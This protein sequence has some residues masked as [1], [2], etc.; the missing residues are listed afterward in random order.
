MLKGTI[1]YCVSTGLARG[2]SAH[3]SSPASKSFWTAWG[4]S[5]SAVFAFLPY[6]AVPGH[7]LSPPGHGTKQEK[8]F[9]LRQKP[10]SATGSGFPEQAHVDPTGPWYLI[11]V[12]RR[13]PAVHG[14]PNRS[15]PAL[16]R[17]RIS[18]NSPA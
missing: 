14:S 12:S 1:F 6:A 9:R 11:P 8:L 16:A 17:A 4:H 13:Q 15:S 2:R 18:R 3:A 5:P 7:C 10:G